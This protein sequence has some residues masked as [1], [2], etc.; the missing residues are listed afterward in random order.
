MTIGVKAERQRRHSTSDPVDCIGWM[1]N[2]VLDTN[3]STPTLWQS[4]L[5]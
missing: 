5:S 4:I 1:R 3:C 2:F